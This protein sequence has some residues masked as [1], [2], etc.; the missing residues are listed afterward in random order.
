MINTQM[1]CGC[2]VHRVCRVWRVCKVKSVAVCCLVFMPL[3]NHQPSLLTA[4]PQPGSPP[5]TR[6]GKCKCAWRMYT[7]YSGYTALPPPT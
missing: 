2:A 7:L 4:R 5:P 6:P 1:K 3:I